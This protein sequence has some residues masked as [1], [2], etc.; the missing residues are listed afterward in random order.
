ADPRALR[1]PR[2]VRARFRDP[3]RLDAR[4][5]RRR[6]ARATSRAA[7]LPAATALAAREPP[8]TIAAKTGV[9]VPHSRARRNAIDARAGRKIRVRQARSTRRPARTRERD[10][11][12]GTKGAAQRGRS[13]FRSDRRRDE[14]RVRMRRAERAKGWGGQRLRSSG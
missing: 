13:F 7:F 8:R 4:S 5:L 2:R 14:T 11:G 10:R 6:R 3:G 12:E 1:R 9:L